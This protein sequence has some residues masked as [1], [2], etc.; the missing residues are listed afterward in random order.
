MVAFT[1]SRLEKLHLSIIQKYF[2]A[3]C[4]D[5]PSLEKIDGSENICLSSTIFDKRV[6][7]LNKIVEVCRKQ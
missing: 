1:G 7:Q 3:L 4:V 2:D 5:Y 6:D